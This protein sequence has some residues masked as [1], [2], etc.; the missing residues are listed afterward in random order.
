VSV[1]ATMKFAK[2]RRLLR[3]IFS[4]LLAGAVLVALAI[5]L[6]WI[7]GREPPSSKGDLV[8]AGAQLPPPSRSLVPTVNFSQ[9]QPW[10][11]SKQPVV[12]HGFRVSAY[13]SGLD[14]PRWLYILPNGDVLVAE[15]STVP[16]RD[17][18]IA[19]AV[20]I[21]LQRDA[22]SVKDSANRIRLLRDSGKL[23]TAAER[24]VF[25]TNLNQPF[26]M[27]LLGD[28]FYVANTDGVW[29]FPYHGGDTHLEGPGEK[30]LDLP[31]DGYNN[32]W[33]RNLI[34]DRAGTKLYV[35]VGSGSNV[36]ENGIDNEFHRA[37]IL[38]FNPDGSG[39]RVFASGLRNPN[40]LAF[41]PSTDTLWT[42]VN[43]RD[44]LG[45]DLVPDYLTSVKDGGFYGWPYS[46]W[47]Q[48]VDGRVNPQRP[49]LIATAITPD[50]ALGAHV[51]ALGLTFNTGDA[52]P[53]HFRGGAFIGEHG[54][55]NRRPF[56]GYK[57]VFVPF[58]DGQPIGKPEDFVTGFMPADQQGVAY[59]R[60][61]GVAIDQT[62]ALRV[63]D[64]VGN[65]VWRIAAERRN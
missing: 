36:G 44:L 8:G 4:A 10:P 23:G 6:L 27:V 55:W 31:A 48:N 30:V 46:Y 57:V 21:W 22:G 26:G 37:N 2:P 14:H 47:G 19:Q 56:A 24:F 12:P 64:D 15:A 58:R 42:V 1:D 51:A 53:E 28:H 50:F 52:F 5:G 38:Q 65:A 35:T 45:N 49:D 63:A 62:G 40:G 9:A 33:T 39:L 20:Q 32:H 34:A 43:E 3:R 59:G 17:R 7:F 61:V 18:S 11:A 13:A 60:P 41:A 29:R 16:R 25:A 54:S